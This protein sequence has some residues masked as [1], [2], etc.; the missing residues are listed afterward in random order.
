MHQIASV[1]TVLPVIQRSLVL[2]LKSVSLNSL[3]NQII[4]WIFVHSNQ[5]LWPVKRSNAVFW[6]DLLIYFVHSFPSMARNQQ[7]YI[8][9]QIIH[10]NQNTELANLGRRKS[11]KI[12]FI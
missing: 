2:E 12:E 7:I 4:F 3:S 1:I 5:K 6:G 8:L 10:T 9:V 11:R